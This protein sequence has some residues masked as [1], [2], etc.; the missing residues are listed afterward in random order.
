[1]AV[2]DIVLPIYNEAEC[3]E[4]SVRRL[5]GYLGSNFP[6]SAV[7]T[8][9]DNAS[10]DAT[11][12]IATKLAHEIP[13]VRVLHLDAKGRGRALKQAWSESGSDVV[14]Y[15]DIDLSTGLEALLP[16][17][18]PLISGHSDIAIGTRLARNSR[19]VRG[20]KRELISRTYN[21][22]LRTLMKSRFTDAQCGFKAMRGALVGVLMPLVED[23]GWFFDTELLLIAERNSLRIHEVPVD[24]IDDP[25]S[26]VDIRGTA[27]GDLLGMWRV[28]RQFATG[29]A[30]IDHGDTGDVAGFTADASRFARMG[31]P[32]TIAWLVLFLALR[33]LLGPIA[34]NV[35]AL[36]ITACGNLAAH[37]RLERGGV[38]RSFRELELV[39]A[40][41]WIVAVALT[42]LAVLAASALSATWL[43]ETAAA[44][45]A[46]ALVS[47]YRFIVLRALVVRHSPDASLYTAIPQNAPRTSPGRYSPPAAASIS[48][49]GRGG[50]T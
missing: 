14:A 1:M 38:S 42:T 21:R 26:R 34:A 25:D 12:R 36:S 33:P 23:D 20:P 39:A 44:V 22:L 30:R 28:T 45:A 15:M 35:L 7:V 32:S 48:R 19:V 2:L 8:I 4:Q 13:G 10:T 9:A 40:G 31:V 18:A 49:T 27:I 47:V 6:F 24:W 17:V 3:L 29:R 5:T 37:R 16:L 50:R 41:S 46:G 11:L 43:P